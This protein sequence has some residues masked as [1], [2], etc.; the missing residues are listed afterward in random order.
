MPV[1]IPNHVPSVGLE[2]LRRVIRE[3]PFD[4]SVDGNAIVIVKRNQL[5]QA[6]RSGQGAGLV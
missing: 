3:P 5:T 4:M 1:N 2:A 6:E